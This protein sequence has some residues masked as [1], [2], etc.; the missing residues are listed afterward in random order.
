MFIQT[1]SFHW[2]IACIYRITMTINSIHNYTKDCGTIILS[3]KL[4]EPG[5]CRVDNGL[6]GMIPV[7]YVYII[8]LCLV[9]H[10]QFIYPG[11]RSVSS[12]PS[13]KVLIIIHFQT[14]I[15]PKDLQHNTTLSSPSL[16]HSIS[17]KEL[18]IL[19]KNN[20]IDSKSI[21]DPLCKKQPYA[22]LA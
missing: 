7:P 6:I 4:P 17:E 20:K 19:I 13:L 2:K 3:Y 10:V 5:E 8:C 15:S 18:L 22:P 1:C 16:T 11:N 14:E 21:S 9:L 12:I